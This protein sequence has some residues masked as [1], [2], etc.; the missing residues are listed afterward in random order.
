VQFSPDD[1]LVTFLQSSEGS[2]AQ[3]L[4]GYDIAKGDRNQLVF[5]GGFRVSLPGQICASELADKMN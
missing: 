3:Q 1:R 2:L 4:F 5:P